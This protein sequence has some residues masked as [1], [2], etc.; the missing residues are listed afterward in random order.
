[1]T[2]LTKVE[3]SSRAFTIFIVLQVLDVLTTLLGLR[4]GAGESNFFIGRLMQLGPLPGLLIS[5][6][7]CLSM[8]VTIVIFGRGRV[9]RLLNPWCAAVVTWNL[10]AIAAQAHFG[11][12][13]V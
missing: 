9:M 10:F 1:M 3:F 8:V 12:H 4:L 2:P 11:M 5:K 7:I 6:L 13:V